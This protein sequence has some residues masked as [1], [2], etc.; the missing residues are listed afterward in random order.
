MS[1]Y[2]AES[3]QRVLKV[4]DVLFGHE[5]NGLTPSQIAQAVDTSASNVT[6]D[7]A[8]LKEAGFAEE[9]MDTG[10]WR[11]SPRHGRRAVALLH[12]FERARN[13]VNNLQDRYT[14]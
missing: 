13:E 14:I 8:N 3:Q 12:T 4:F 2:T 1:K 9:V 6:R 10:A 7:L 11:I 5:I